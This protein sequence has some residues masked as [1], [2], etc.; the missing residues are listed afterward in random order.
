VACGL[1][2]G[3][4]GLWPVAC[5]LGPG[6]W[7]L[8]P[9]AWGL[10]PGGCWVALGCWGVVCEVW[11]VG[12]GVWTV[13]VLTQSHQ[14]VCVRQYCMCQLLGKVVGLVVLHCNYSSLGRTLLTLPPRQRCFLWYLHKARSMLI[15]QHGGQGSVCV[16]KGGGGARSF[17]PSLADLG[18]KTPGTNHARRR[19][20]VAEP[21][22]AIILPGNMHGP[23]VSVIEGV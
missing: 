3:A 23:Q 22:A 4:W 18:K 9:G 12:C 10:G 17:A 19:R 8:G 6:V 16:G 13:P 7:A 21:V 20:R 14:M 2:P 11:D 5:G 1:W 15:A